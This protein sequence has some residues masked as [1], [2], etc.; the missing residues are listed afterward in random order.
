MSTQP[1]AHACGA[2]ARNVPSTPRAQMASRVFRAIAISSP[3][4][5]LLTQCA[6]DDAERTR[7]QDWFS[8]SADVREVCVRQPEVDRFGGALTERDSR[9][10][11]EPLDGRRDGRRMLRYEE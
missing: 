1:W 2:V 4:R 10:S 6:N 8:L 7:F 5:D 9:E 11:S 3:Y